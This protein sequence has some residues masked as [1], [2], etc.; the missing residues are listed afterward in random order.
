M[1]ASVTFE[2]LKILIGKKEVL[3]SSHGYDELAEDGLL[4][5]DVILTVNSGIVIEDYHDFAKGPCCLVLQKDQGGNPIH[6]VWGISKGT[7][8]PAVLITA[9]KPDPNRWTDDFSRR[10]DA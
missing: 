9:Y 6:V 2:T 4:V 1:I 8:T 3:I 5:K 10:I 7:E